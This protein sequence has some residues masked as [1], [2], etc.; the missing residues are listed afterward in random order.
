MNFM[1]RM[2]LTAVLVLFFSIMIDSSQLSVHAAP[3]VTDCSE[4]PELEGC[5]SSSPEEGEGNSSAQNA[6]E[7]PSIIWNIIKL[8]FALL[9]VLALIYGLLKFF[10]K[11]NKLFQK[12]RAMEALGG[13]TL[14]PN[15][16]LQAVRIGEKYFVVGVGESI[17]LI[18][19][20]TDKQTIESLTRE[21][22]DFVNKGVNH[23]KQLSKKNQSDS[24]RKNSTIQFQQLFEKQL[25]EMKEKR[26]SF[27]KKEDDSL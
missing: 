18:T 13:I 1:L 27:S 22:S 5:G 24:T 3:S 25:K 12:S 8:I 14:A 20:I 4:N 21:E 11:R 23:I 15:R 7:S 17:D 2:L 19:E 10:N 9:V 16:S 26:K 6:E